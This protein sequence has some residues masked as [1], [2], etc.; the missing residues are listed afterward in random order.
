MGH[1]SW[2]GLGRIWNLETARFVFYPSVSA[3]GRRACL[4]RPEICRPFGVDDAVLLN[5]RE[6]DLPPIPK[7]GTLRHRCR[8]RIQEGYVKP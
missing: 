6:A 4:E 7:G 8:A 5:F 1:L 3:R 2:S